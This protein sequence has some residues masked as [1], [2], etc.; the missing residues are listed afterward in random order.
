MARSKQI[1]ISHRGNISEPNPEKENHPDYIMEA[2]N[3]DY[4]VEVDIWMIDGKFILGHDKPQYEVDRNFLVRWK[5]IMWQHAK[6]IEA[7]VAL[8]ND[9]SEF[10][11]CFFHHTDDYTLTPNA[12]IWTYP[13]KKIISSN[14]V[15]VLPE[16]V[17]NWDISL[18]GGICT[19]YPVKYETR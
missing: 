1:L 16:S 8:T 5:D 9:A 18:A 3:Q 4:E 11:N 19:D 15:A 14:S 7:L 13:G 6:N 10:C 2:L 17:D 12:W